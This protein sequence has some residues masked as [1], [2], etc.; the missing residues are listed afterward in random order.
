MVKQSSV[1]H[2]VKGYA[3]VCTA[4][5]PSGTG[6]REDT[7]LVISPKEQELKNQMGHAH[8]F[9]T[10]AVPLKTSGM[11][12]LQNTEGCVAAPLITHT[13]RLWTL[14]G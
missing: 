11:I 7:I 3:G 2:T 12:P 9:R 10:E 4:D 5:R 8:S 1:T 6:G 13:S 14:Q